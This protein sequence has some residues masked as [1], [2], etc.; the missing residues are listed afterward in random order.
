MTIITTMVKL[1]TAMIVGIFVGKK[2][3]IDAE[4]SKRISKLIVD[5]ANP[6]LIIASVTSIQGADV[7]SVLSALIFG[8]IIYAILPFVAFGYAKGIKAPKNL[9]GTFMLTVL[10]CN[11][12]FMG[13]PVV[14][15]LLG[16]KAIFY[17]VVIHFGFNILFYTVGINLVKR[18]AADG[19][20][21]KWNPLSLINTGTVATL[22]VLIVFLS[23]ANVPEIVTEPL[24]FVGNLSMP[25]SMIIIGANISRHSL[26][27]IL[28]DKKVYL[29][30]VMRLVIVPF[31]IWLAASTFVGDVFVVRV[32][33][34]TFAMPVAAIVAMSTAPYEEQGEVA[35]VAVAFTTLCSLITIPMWAMF[36]G[37]R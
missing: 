17:D 23:G 1:F 27:D 33:T 9:T 12:S 22:T 11:N 18:D 26:K 35:S 4:T 19:K 31:L 37:L 7:K 28:K 13:F 20:Q 15:A 16:D 3:I 34:L 32:A 6:A 8:L 5:I 25:M 24:S 29:T 21:E 10:L 2:D 36:L 30:A 14:Q